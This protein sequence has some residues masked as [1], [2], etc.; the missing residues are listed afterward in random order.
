[1][2]TKD[3]LCSV[4]P[5]SCQ[6]YIMGINRTGGQDMKVSDI[7]LYKVNERYYLEYLDGRIEQVILAG[8]SATWELIKKIVT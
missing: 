2:S 7:T 3:T 4:L 6:F 1:M 8:D 5:N